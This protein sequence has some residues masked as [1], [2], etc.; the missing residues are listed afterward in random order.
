MLYAIAANMKRRHN[1][2]FNV[3]RYT[4]GTAKIEYFTGPPAMIPSY[5]VYDKSLQR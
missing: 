3:K 2:T 4:D 1:K 5:T